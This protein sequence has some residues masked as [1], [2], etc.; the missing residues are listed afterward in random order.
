M[1]HFNCFVQRSNGNLKTR[2]FCSKL[3]FS[4]YL[5]HNFLKS[6]SAFVPTMNSHHD[7]DDDSAILEVYTFPNS[8]SNNISKPTSKPGDDVEVWTIPSPKGNNMESLSDLKPASKPRG[9]TKGKV[10]KD[11]KARK[12]RVSWSDKCTARSWKASMKGLG[13]LNVSAASRTPGKSILLKKKL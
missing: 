10:Q 9:K 2:F 12:G 6:K 7:D 3:E 8:K 1:E 5:V 4:I 13:R 11:K